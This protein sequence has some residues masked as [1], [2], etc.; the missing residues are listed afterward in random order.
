MQKLTVVTAALAAGVMTFAFSAANAASLSPRADQ[1]VIAVSAKSGKATLARGGK[2]QASHGAK[3]VSAKAE[4][5]SWTKKST[6]KR[7]TKRGRKTIDMT[8]TASIG[9]RNA[10]ASTAAVAS[11]GQYSAIVA[12]YAASYGVPVS[13]AHAVIRIESNYRPNMV[14]SAGEIG[15][16]QIK[17]ATARMM[18]YNG[19]AK[20]LFDPDTNIKYG[21][22]YLAMAQDLGGGTTCGTILKYN[23][24]HAATRMNPVSAAYCSK[25]KV[26]MAA[27]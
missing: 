19:S 12:R 20:G 23:A 14:G 18:G 7:Q 24:G 2:T 11:G 27:L 25:V 1:G 17:P 5:V 15:L 21:M 13:L 8:T 9:L 22:K 10:A 3:R 26:Q 16:M 4:K 6:A